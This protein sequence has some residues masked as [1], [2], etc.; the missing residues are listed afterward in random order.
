MSSMSYGE[1]VSEFR[2]WLSRISR[3]SVDSVVS[4]LQAFSSAVAKS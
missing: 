2:G 3:S 4:E 1:G